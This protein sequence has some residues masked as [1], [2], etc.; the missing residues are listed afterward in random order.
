MYTLALLVNLQSIVYTFYS[1]ILKLLFRCGILN[2]YNVNELYLLYNDYVN[3][4][5]AELNKTHYDYIPFLHRVM[6]FLEFLTA[7]LLPQ[8]LPSDPGCQTHHQLSIHS[9]PQT[10]PSKSPLLPAL[11][12]RTIL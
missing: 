10:P 11:F 4:I 9:F 12:P 7:F 1:V 6:F 8:C 5:T 2:V 3:V